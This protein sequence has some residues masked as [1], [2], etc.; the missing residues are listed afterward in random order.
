[1]PEEL[2]DDCRLATSLTP[3]H[4]QAAARR[5]LAHARARLTRALRTLH[6]Q[7]YIAHGDWRAMHDIRSLDR[8]Q[9]EAHAHMQ[10]VAG[11]SLALPSL[12]V[13]TP[14]DRARAIEPWTRQGFAYSS[15]PT[16]PVPLRQRLTSA[17]TGIGARLLGYR[18]SL[19]RVAPGEVDEEGTPM[20]SE[21]TVQAL[22]QVSGDRWCRVYIV[23]IDAEDGRSA[24]LARLGADAT[25]FTIVACPR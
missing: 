6:R 24:E 12:E 25:V 17:L 14:E 3:E 20:R 16:L 22:V 7:G 10:R 19:F 15:E 2:D 1:M 4:L 8:M 18:A 11:A 23:R 9:R 5:D 13:P 21:W